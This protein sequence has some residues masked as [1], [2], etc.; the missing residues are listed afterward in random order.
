[1]F[2]FNACCS[3]ALIAC[4]R[5]MLLG[6]LAIMKRLQS[7]QIL[8]SWTLAASL[9]TQ[10][11]RNHRKRPQ[12]TTVCCIVHTDRIQ[13]TTWGP[14]CCWN[15]RGSCEECPLRPTIFTLQVPNLLRP[16]LSPSQLETLPVR[17][18]T[19]ARAKRMHCPTSQD[20]LST[21]LRCTRNL[22]LGWLVGPGSQRQTWGSK[23]AAH[24]QNWK[25]KG[26]AMKPVRA[27]RST[28]L[29]ASSHL[30]LFYSFQKYCAC[31]TTSWANKAMGL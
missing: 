28:A 21:F 18:L 31:L 5:R 27:C 19:G 11:L 3:S 2:P 26:P 16:S 30:P 8:F 20:D 17:I 12:S 15:W 10:A 25:N 1:M 4:S 24:I 22:T 9:N 29:T 14:L 7:G 23:R 13:Q 6:D